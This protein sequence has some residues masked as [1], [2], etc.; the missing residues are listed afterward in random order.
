M[1]SY[2]NKYQKM[3]WRRK[4]KRLFVAATRQNVGKTTISLGILAALRKHFTRDVGF[5]KPV[6]QRYLLEN[7]YKIDEDSLL[8]DRLF[9]FDCPLRYLSPVAIEKGYTEDFLDG[10]VSGDIAR[11]IRSAFHRVAEGKEAVVIEGTGHAGVGSV[12]DMSNGQ[13]A[14]M[15]NSDVVLV[16]PGGIG[17]PID[18]IMLNKSLFDSLG[19]RVAGVIVNKVLPHKYKKIDH[20]LRLGLK[21]LGVPLFGVIP[22][23]NLLEMPSLFDFREELD[24]HVLC[25]E[26]HLLKPIKKVL[27]GAMEVREAI[28]YLENNSLV[29]TPGNRA[30]LLNLLIKVHTSRYRKHVNI[31]GIILSGGLFPKKRLLRALKRTGIPTL[32]SNDD[33]Y[34]VASSVHSL[35]VK[36]KSRDKTKVK[37]AIDMIEKHLNLSHL[38]DALF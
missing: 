30:D 10:K 14:K 36:I 13:V 35:T 23:A 34:S 27:V 19:V 24:M 8:M 12:F 4:P 11:E 29:I 6:G 26:E 3:F 31:A 28:N 33:T 20:Y 25:G 15:L 5:I 9:H 7:G 21:R 1:K 32:A 37:L 16:A 18:E 22:Y 38:T 2:L 17:N